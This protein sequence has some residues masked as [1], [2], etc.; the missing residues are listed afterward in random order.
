M[1]LDAELPNN[2]SQKKSQVAYSEPKQDAELPRKISDLTNTQT[3]GLCYNK[4]EPE[5]FAEQPGINEEIDHPIAATDS[6]KN[7]WQMP[8]PINLNSSG[9]HPS[10]KTEV[11]ATTMMNQNAHLLLASSQTTHLHLASPQSF[12]STHIPLS[13]NHSNLSSGLTNWVQSL[14]VKVHV[15][16]TPKVSC[17]A[18]ALFAFEPITSSKQI[19]LPNTALNATAEMQLP[20]DISQDPG[21]LAEQPI[22]ATNSAQYN[23]PEDLGLRAA[24][25]NPNKMSWLIVRYFITVRKIQQY[26]NQLQHVLVNLSLLKAFFIAKLNSISIK[27]KANSPMLIDT[28]MFQQGAMI[29]FN[30][31]WITFLGDPFLLS[32]LRYNY[33]TTS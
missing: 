14:V 32:R 19:S 27:A 9:L 20:A 4:S 31:G 33:S 5:S 12:S 3:C 24:S 1:N 7:K 25:K 16:S 23:F 10:S 15:S 21:P 26:Q 17:H 8:T 6:S 22:A 2:L 30:N 18:F 28:P 11:L 29:H 13:T